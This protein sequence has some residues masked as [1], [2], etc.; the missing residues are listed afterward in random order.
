MN[1]R[2]EEI[3]RLRQLD[4]FDHRTFTLDCHVIGVGATGS[5]AVD[6]LGSFGV[7]R[8][9]VYDD[10]VITA[11]NVPNQAYTPHHLGM[12]KVDATRERLAAWTTTE[13]VPHVEKVGGAHRF[14]GVVF[15][16]VADMDTRR[17]IWQ[18][19]LRYQLSVPFVVET[20][21]AAEQGRIYALVPV[22]PLHVE[23]WEADSQY[24]SGHN[25]AQ[26][27]TNRAIRST[28]FVLAGLAVHQLTLWHR[29]LDYANCQIV[30]LK[31]L[32][33]LSAEQWM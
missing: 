32:T 22:N 20:R 8:I 33:L 6:I 24:P 17:T 26:D 9:H 31:G 16:C 5:W 18:H 14:D 15:L 28:V 13:V 2:V 19:C 7:P 29:R 30:A 12:R 1:G 27:C 4:I 21:M 10:D 11:H 3:S 25:E 23:R